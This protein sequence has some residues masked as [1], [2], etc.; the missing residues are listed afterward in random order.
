MNLTHI[1]ALFCWNVLV[2]LNGKVI[3]GI[4][5]RNYVV[6]MR[7]IVVYFSKIKKVCFGSFI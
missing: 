4:Y 2:I 5:L 3:K 1:L 7:K 6:I